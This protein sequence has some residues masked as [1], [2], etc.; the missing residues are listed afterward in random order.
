[1]LKLLEFLK[2][3]NVFEDDYNNFENDQDF[4]QFLLYYSVKGP[5]THN[6]TAL[7]TPWFSDLLN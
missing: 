3:F 6:S 1:M 4:K 7:A 2:V 5:Y